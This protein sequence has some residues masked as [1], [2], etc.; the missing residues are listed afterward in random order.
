MAVTVSNLIYYPIK[1]CAGIT[2]DKLT[3][4]HHG[5]VMDRRFVIVN[6]E[7]NKALT[8]REHPKL[9]LVTPRLH[10]DGSTMTITAP[11]MPILEVN[12]REFEGLPRKLTI[13]A[14]ICDGL[15]LDPYYSEWFSQFL[16][17]ECTLV[18]HLMHYPRYREVDG[19]ARKIEVAFQ[20]GWP[21]LLISEASLEDLNSR[22]IAKGNEP[23]PMNRFRPNVVL[24]GCDP[25][26]E[27]TLKLFEFLGP[28]PILE[29]GKNCPRCPIVQT[30]QEEGARTSKEPLRTLSEYRKEPKGVVFGRYCDVVSAGVIKLGATLARKD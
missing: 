14:D 8:Q 16:G 27:D 21:L 15:T 25:Y 6:R 1:S 26:E 2:T 5:G 9:A 24:R 4:S 19:L 23:V 22:L 28:G 18:H 10:T 12:L 7:N 17:L 3:V 13:H 20:D 29:G 30:N 11:E